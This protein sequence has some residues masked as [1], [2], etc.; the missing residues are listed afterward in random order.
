LRASEFGG[1]RRV[2]AQHHLQA[3]HPFARTR[4]HLVRHRRRADLS[5]RESLGD[6][7]VARHQ[8]D[9]VRQRRR[10]GAELDECGHH[11]V[12]Q[13]PRVHLPDAGEN[14]CEAQ[15]F[16]YPPLQRSQPRGIAVEQIEHVLRGAHGPLDAAQRVAVDQ[17]REARQ[18]DQRLLGRRG[19]PLAE[20]RRLGGDVVRTARHHQVA[21]QVGTLGQP[22]DD[23]HPVGVY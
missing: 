23:C 2:A 13:R 1:H 6:E 16:G 5:R 19:E 8:P 18:C 14:V 21:V 17:L 15:E 12:V 7:L 4:V 22:S 3:V 20:R 11:V 10:P 9:G